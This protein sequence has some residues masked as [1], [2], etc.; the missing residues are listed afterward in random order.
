MRPPGVRLGRAYF[1]YSREG[2]MVSPASRGAQSPAMRVAI[3]AISLL[4]PVAAQAQHLTV[5]AISGKPLKLN[6]SNTTNPD[7]SAVG[8]TAVRLTQ[9]PAHGRVI[10]S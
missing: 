5:V 2:F 8:A 9:A 1:N 4:M 7:C 10:I 3:I 6:F